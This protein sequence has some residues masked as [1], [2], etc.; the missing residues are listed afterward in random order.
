MRD[1]PTDTRDHAEAIRLHALGHPLLLLHY[2]FHHPVQ[3]HAQYH[4]RPPRSVRTNEVLG[5]VPCRE[6]FFHDRVGFCALTTALIVP[7]DP[8]RCSTRAVVYGRCARNHA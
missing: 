6:V 3:V 4:Q 1:A 2:S 8:L 5:K 7:P